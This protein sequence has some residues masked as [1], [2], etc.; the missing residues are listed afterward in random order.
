[1][2]HFLVFRPLRNAAPL[3]KVIGSVGVLLYLH[4]VAQLNFG[5]SDRQPEEHPAGQA[6]AELPLPR[7]RPSRRTPCGRPASPCSSASALWALFRFTRFGLATRAAAGNEKGAV[8][9]GYS[10]QFLAAAQL[11][12][13][14]GRRR[15]R[16]DHR[17]PAAGLADA[18]RPHRAGRRL[19]RRRDARRRCSSIMVATIGG[20][21]ARLGAGAAPVLVV[22]GLVPAASSAPASREVLP[23]A[24]DRGRAVRPRQEAARPRHGRGEAPAAVAQTGADVA[25]HDH[26]ERWS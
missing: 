16:G 14:R 5:G 4:G 13:R 9:L 23:F 12:D 17:R 20:L 22:E 6:A 2:V 21:A 7:C 10:P 1:M 11:G 3:G 15:L 26:L 24:G 18:D 19:L 25:A 8:L